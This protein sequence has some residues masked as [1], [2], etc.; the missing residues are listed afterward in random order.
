LVRTACGLS[1]AVALLVGVTGCPSKDGSANQVSGKVTL[2]GEAVAGTVIFVGPDGKE[3]PTPI[4]ANGNYKLDDPPLGKCKVLVK[5]MG[6]AIGGPIAAKD[7]SAGTKDAP[8]LGGGGAAPPAKY[9]DVKTTDLEFEVKA[10]KQTID[11][12]LKS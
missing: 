3:K 7:A 4:M 8:K 12:P 5:G 9:G 11:I 2:G 1:L 6:G 10:G